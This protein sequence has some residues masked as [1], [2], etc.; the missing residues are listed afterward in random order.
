[1]L[2]APSKCLQTS[3]K[4]GCNT[5]SFQRHS[6]EDLRSVQ[7]ANQQ[8]SH[9]EVLVITSLRPV[10][11]HIAVFQHGE[12]LTHFYFTLS[13]RPVAMKREQ[14]VLLIFCQC[15]LGLW[16]HSFKGVVKVR[17]QPQIWNAL[18][19]MPNKQLDLIYWQQNV[20]TCRLM[21]AGCESKHVC[22]NSYVIKLLAPL[23][24]T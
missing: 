1:M 4:R 17:V 14:H 18:N 16:L 3:I 13:C 10:P 5:L 24:N 7:S 11:F 8:L 23:S 6:E 9:A 19:R 12:K 2:T 20:L 22:G 15:T 21:I